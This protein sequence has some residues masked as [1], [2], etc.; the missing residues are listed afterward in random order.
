MNEDLILNSIM[1]VLKEMESNEHKT[2]RAKEVKVGVSARHIHLSQK[3]LEILFGEGFKL[4]VK[5]ELMAGEFASESCIT[6]VGKNM[7]VIEKVRVLGPAREKT[8][9]E[10]SKSDC[11]NLGLQ[12]KV[13]LSGDLE[14]AEKIMIV[15]PEGA[16]T[17]EAAIISKRHIHISPEIKKELNIGDTVGI[18]VHGERGGI[19]SNV[20]VR[21][22]KGYEFML[23]IDTDEANGL[24]IKC[25]QYLEIYEE[26]L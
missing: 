3:D 18:K 16:V 8:Q 20:V 10:I 25:G 13:K 4:T 15:G 23:H 5:K 19:L 1:K 22:K 14:G 12:G 2:N 7:R 21:S 26:S 9:V 24:G 11:I 6:L 17:R